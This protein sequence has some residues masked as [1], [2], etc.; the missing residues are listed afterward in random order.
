MTRTSKDSRTYW[1]E[2]ELDHARSVETDHKKIMKDIVKMYEDTGREIEKEINNLISKY[3][4]DKGISLSDAK[5][6][7]SEIDI[8]DYEDKARRYVRDRDF[9]K[10]ANEEMK[11]YNLKMKVSRLELTQ[12]YIDLELI[13]LT[14]RV[15]A[16]IYDRLSLVVFGEVERKAG[17][18]GEGIKVSQ[19][20]IAY[21]VSRKFHGDDFSN[22]LW[23]D[24]ALLHRELNKR[25][26]ESITR[27]QHPRQAARKLRDM[28]DQSVYVA[29]RLL[30]TE[31]ARVQ[32][33]SQLYAYDRA[34]VEEY[35]FVTTEGA[36]M[37]C[38]PMD[39]EVFEVTDARP[40]VNISPIHPNCRCSTIPIVDVT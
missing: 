30:V 33:E 6:A 12:S 40:G 20:E 4:T 36:C 15:D 27:G 34:D 24:K 37:I 21:I 35:E 13:A 5:K 38:G 14:D 8:R 1:I 17:I 19:K 7:V 25:L 18:L 23:R 39:G 28:I 3:A 31:T 11:R 2:R 26:S 29:D 16:E 22:R 32:S 10:R 9:S